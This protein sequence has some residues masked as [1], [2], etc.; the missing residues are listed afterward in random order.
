MLGFLKKKDF[1]V[2]VDNPADFRFSVE[3]DT[4]KY[5]TYSKA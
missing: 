2:Q 5:S 1:A 4:S 3:K